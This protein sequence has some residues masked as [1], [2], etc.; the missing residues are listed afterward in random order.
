M[1]HRASLLRIFEAAVQ[2][3]NGR[4]RVS[5][6]LSRHPVTGLGDA[7]PIYVV[8]TGKAAPSML[9]GALEILGPRVAAALAIT[10]TGHCTPPRGAGRPDLSCRNV[11]C[12]E[13]GHPYPDERS[14]SAGTALLDFIQGVPERTLFLFLV[15]GGTSALVECLPQGIT[16]ADLGRA[17]RW[18]LASGLDIRCVNRVRQGLSLI[19]GGRLLRYLGGR[20][21]LN[22]LISDVPGDDPAIIGSGLLIAGRESAGL[23]GIALPAWL[24]S[25]LEKAGMEKTGPPADAHARVRTELVACTRDARASARS[26]GESLG[27][28]VEAHETFIDGD[29]VRAGRTLA[30]ALLAGP[31]GLHVWSG[32]TTL[33]LPPH[34]GRGGRC[35]SLALAAALGL[36][37]RRDAWLLAAGTD[38]TD[39]PTDAA[40][41]LVDGGTVE[42]GERAGLRAEN[43]LEAA[44][45]GRFLGAA[46]DLVRTGPTGTNVMDLMLGLRV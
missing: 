42:R 30:E 46:G 20:P 24:S 7:G 39:G 3:V 34:P 29:A 37:G 32:E 33:R 5:D 28:R 15:S 9:E 13:A 40:G 22:L 36:R 45:A 44:D 2:A 1:D 19:K 17:N 6:Y 41:A 4:V 21:A 23:G 14:L 25:L 8:A 10:K 27:Y 35:Q 31:A 38:G 16:L 11:T 12:L 26:V 18:L 43:C